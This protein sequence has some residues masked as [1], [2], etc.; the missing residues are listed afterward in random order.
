M[1]DDFLQVRWIRMQPFG[2]FGPGDAR[3]AMA[4]T[5]PWAV[6]RL[7]PACTLPGC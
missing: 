4:L 2:E 5:Q 1:I 3:P 7:A 6:E